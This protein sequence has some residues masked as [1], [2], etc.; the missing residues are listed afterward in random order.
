MSAIDALRGRTASTPAASASGVE[1]GQA[2]VADLSASSEQ[3]INLIRKMTGRNMSDDLVEIINIALTRL[4]LVDRAAYTQMMK[5]IKSGTKEKRAAAP[6][7]PVKAATPKAAPK[8]KPKAPAAA[9]AT[10]TPRRKPNLKVGESIIVKPKTFK[11][12]GQQ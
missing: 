11:V 7:A 8:A 12:W 1:A 9:P 4:R 3:I 6:A 2:P 10:T 5:D